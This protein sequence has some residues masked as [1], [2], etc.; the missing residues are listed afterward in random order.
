MKTA[1]LFPPQWFPSQPYLAT[2]TL[3]GYLESKGLEVDQYD[4]NIESYDFFL[5]RSYLEYCVEKIKYRLDAPSQTLDEREVKKIYHQILSP[6][7][8]YRLSPYF[9]KI[10]FL[11]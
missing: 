4:L 2:P 5:S 11:I 3:K 6:V 8:V 9:C 1:L 7:L 10:V